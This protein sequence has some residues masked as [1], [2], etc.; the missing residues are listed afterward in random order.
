MEPVFPGEIPVHPH[1]APVKML[2]KS[3]V[4]AAVF[5]WPVLIA[6]GGGVG[7]D[8]DGLR[9]DSLARGRA[10]GGARARLG[11]QAPTRSFWYVGR[12]AGI[13]F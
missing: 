4:D 10:A 1:P 11:C 13:C 12:I 8:R 3:V 9:D 6:G 7:V 5:C 2:S